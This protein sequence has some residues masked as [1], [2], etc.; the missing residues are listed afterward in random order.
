MIH[1]RINLPF[2][3]PRWPAAVGVAA[4]LVALAAAIIY[5]R[6]DLG[7][8]HYDARAHLVV[9]RRVIDSLTPGWHQIGAVWLPLP[10]VLNLL[11]VQWD[12]AYRTGASATLMS[13][14]CMGVSAFAGARLL[15]RATGSRLAGAACAALLVTNVNVLY[16]HA[17]PMTEPL[18]LA[19][20]FLAVERLDA[21]LRD[22][23][24]SSVSPGLALFLLCLTRYE[25]WALTAAAMGIAGLLSLAR[26]PVFLREGVKGSQAR[27]LFGAPAP[28]LSEGIPDQAPATSAPIRFY[29]NRWLLLALWPAAAV[30]GFLCLS[31]ATVGAWFVS[32]GFYVA[33][34]PARGDVGLVLEQI[35]G[36]VERLSSPAYAAFGAL[37][38][39]LVAVRGAASRHHRAVLVVL[40]LAAMA[41]LPLVAFHAGHPFRIRYM[42]P[43]VAAS[44]LF[45]GFAIGLTPPVGRVLMLAAAALLIVPDLKPFDHTAPMVVEA[46][47]E[48]RHQ[49]NRRAVTAALRQ[50]W[51]GTPI[52]M[53]MGSFAHYMHDLGREGFDIADFLHEGNGEIWNAAVADPA[54]HVRFLIVEERAE[55]GDMFAHLLK[56]RPEVAA[57][58]Q[59]LAAGG[60]AAL[61][62]RIW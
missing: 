28:R 27:P 29:L 44:A 18:L 52:L 3:I 32:D 62:R 55:G 17:T 2:T 14:V 42:T 8:S 40:S 43:L 12:W 24:M 4:A 45:T 51:D 6:H 60:N 11:P 20:A 58:F 30:V 31:K 39:V 53:S 50:A 48:E 36:G 23:E 22:P 49:V 41:A 16:L 35:R 59:R 1:S 38:L 57:R 13:V 7:I 56:E 9:A 47:R 33:D 25:G 10:H 21:W 19:L 61:Y 15:E 37:G 5:A 54:S 34:N 26:C 46:R